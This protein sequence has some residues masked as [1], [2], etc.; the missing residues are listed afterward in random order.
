ML[1]C[2]TGKCS[3]LAVVALQRAD[4][5]QKKIMEVRDKIPGLFCLCPVFLFMLGYFCFRNVM[6][7]P[8]LKMWLE[9]RTSLKS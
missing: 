6:G 3:W 5:A 4:P 1:F 7:P 2:F 9:S 8:K